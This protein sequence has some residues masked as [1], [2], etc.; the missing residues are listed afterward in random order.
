MGDR[1]HTLIKNRTMK[2][3]IIALSGSGGDEGRVSRDDL[4]KYILTKN[5]VKK[6]KAEFCL[7]HTELD[8]Y[9]LS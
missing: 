7:K 3:L 9:N 2:P 8:V 6:R 4:T 5:E 1:V